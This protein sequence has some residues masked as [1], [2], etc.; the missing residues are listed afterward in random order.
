MF[1]FF[2][3]VALLASSLSISTLLSSKRQWKYLDKNL[4]KLFWRTGAPVLLRCNLLPF[5]GCVLKVLNGL[6]NG[7]LFPDKALTNVHNQSAREMMLE[8]VASCLSFFI[9]EVT[10]NIDFA[11]KS[12]GL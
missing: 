11:V 4:H 2:S 12:S 5:K 7:C 3:S 6:L 9:L 10:L 1:T 8:M